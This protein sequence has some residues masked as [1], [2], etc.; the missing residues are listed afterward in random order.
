MHSYKK[1]AA[2]ITAAAISFSMLAGCG[3]SDGNA[4]ETAAETTQADAAQ[5]QL[6]DVYVNPDWSYGQVAI[7]G[8]GFVTG[9]VSTCEA[10]LFYARTDVGGAYRWDDSE[11]KMDST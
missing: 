2:L 5:E 4:D 7:G 9:I 6:A 10:G 8:G 3:K 1:A 11:K